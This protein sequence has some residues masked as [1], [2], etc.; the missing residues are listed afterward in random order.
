MSY[1]RL[2]EL[3]GIQWPCPDEQH[4]GTLF[5]HARLWEEARPSA[6]RPPR[7]RRGAR[8]AGRRAV[9]GVP[10][11]AHHRAPPRL[12]QHR[13][14]DRRL[15]LAAR[16]RGDARHVARGRGRLG[17]PTARWCGSSSRR[18]RVEA[19]VRIDDGAAGRA[20]VH[21]P[22]L[23]RRGRDQRAHHRRLGSQVGHGRV[24]GDGDP[25]GEAG[26]PAAG[27]RRDQRAEAGP[28]GSAA[29]GRGASDRR[30]AAAVDAVLGPPD[31]AGTGA[32]A[33]R[34]TGTSR[35][36]ATRRGPSGTCCCR[37]CTRCRS[38]RLGQPRGA[39]LRLRPAHHAAGRG[40]R[41]G[42]VLRPVPHDAV[43]RRG[44]AR[45]RRHRLPGQRRRAG[46]RADGAP[47]RRRGHRGRGQR[48]R[49]SPGSAAPASATA[50]AARRRW[51]SM[52]APTRP[53][54]GW[55]R[56]IPR[57]CGRR[58]HPLRRASPS[59]PLVPQI[60]GRPLL[61]PAAAARGAGRPGLARR[62]PRG[63][64]IRGAPPGVHA[65]ARRA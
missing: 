11:P 55:P 15:R 46:L 54:P 25:R 59:P 33:R 16:R 29:R 24:Q 21:D 63:G 23:P 35:S 7:S 20:G 37:C 3:G 17:W 14:A 13:R 53:G 31:P 38:G 5:L 42:V 36:A 48:Q 56:S 1:P 57:R 65:R 32:S 18:G 30:R 61:A 49:A 62:L 9:G 27:R 64:R 60:G 52:R 50:T 47:V 19:P 45:L 58:S 12:V 4:P 10:A 34:P 28:D 51:S 41:G 44:G 2:E 8:A 40:V 26:R 43:A 39:R 22:A 6:G